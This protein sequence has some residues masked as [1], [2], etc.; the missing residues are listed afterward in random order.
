VDG[1]VF[2]EVAVG[3]HVRGRRHQ[4]RRILFSQVARLLSS[5]LLTQNRG[6][7][8]RLRKRTLLLQQFRVGF[9]PAQAVH[10]SRRP[11]FQKRI[12]LRQ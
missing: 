10:R 4:N 6:A 8:K 1:D 5:R 3:G 7:R 11:R 12:G 9:A 2:A